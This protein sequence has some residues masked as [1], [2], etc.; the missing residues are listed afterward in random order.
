M[1][2]NDGILF[3]NRNYDVKIN[4]IIC[5]APAR[6]MLKKCKGHTGYNACERCCEEGASIKGRMTFPGHAANERTDDSFKKKDD[7]EHHVGTSSFNRINVGLVT[8]FV[9]DYTHLI[10]LFGITRKL[11]FL[12]LKGP[13]KCRQPSHI[14]TAISDQLSRIRSEIPREFARKPRALHEVSRWKATELRQFLL[15]TGPIVLLKK[16]P[17]KLYDHFLLLSVAMYILL[18]PDLCP[19][20]YDYAGKLLLLF[21]KN[22]GNLYGYEFLVYN[23]HSLI[24]L[25]KDAE[26]YGSL[27]NVSAF[28]FE[29]FLGKLKCLVRRSKNPV[30]QIVRRITEKKNTNHATASK[31]VKE[32]PTCKGLHNQGLLPL[33]H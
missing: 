25:H 20:F 5:D 3:S 4:A 7:D 24:H 9:L 19:L 11:L 8:H 33:C 1:L 22:F 30:P 12:W 13:L 16:L 21:F 29:N 23:T 17:S 31:I 10:C 32:V 28:P 2:E 14:I 26:K 27:D 15:Y 6:A 18:H